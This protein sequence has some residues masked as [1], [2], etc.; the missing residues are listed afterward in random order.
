MAWTIFVEDHQRILQNYIEF[1]PV[2]SD[3]KIFYVFSEKNLFFGSVTQICNGP[4][5]FEQLWKKT[6]QGSFLWSLV[7]IQS[8]V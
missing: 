2:V 3:K 6:I 8:V 5:P 4:E 7:K 1:G